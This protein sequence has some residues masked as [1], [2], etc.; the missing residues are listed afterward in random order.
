MDRFLNGLKSHAA[1]LDRAQ[2]QARFGI[3]ASM[4]MTRYAARVRLQPED[5]LT[6]WLPVLTPWMGANW[7]L[8]APLSPGDQVLV[9]AQ[10]GDA[11]HGVIIGASFSQ[12]Q[13]PPAAIPGELWLVHATGTSLHF[14]NDG[15]VRV[16]GD[17]HVNG[18]VYDRI[19]P[20]SRLR[21][22]YDAH[23]HPPSNSTTNLP[24]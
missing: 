22:K 13:P 2:G 20:L 15:T 16:Q 11:D 7:G 17:L 10:E 23:V 4:D 21:S 8:V 5:V 12:V 3:V 1:A 24:D 9:I 18:D 6:G 14:A 19:G